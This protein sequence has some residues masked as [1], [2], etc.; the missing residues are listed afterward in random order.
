MRALWAQPV[1]SYQGEYVAFEAV[2]CNPR[3]LQPGGIPIH[4]GGHSP[5]AARRAGRLGDGFLPLGGS[6]EELG[7]LFK[8]VEETARGAGRDPGAIELSTIGMASYDSATAAQQ[9]GAQRM[10][11]GSSDTDLE[12]AK[13]ILGKFSDEV[14][15]RL[16]SA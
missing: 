14:I 5:A 11:I 8:I 2:K 1:A 10:L 13:S 16:G 9:A 3:P 4:I 15:A 7:G 6:P 12:S